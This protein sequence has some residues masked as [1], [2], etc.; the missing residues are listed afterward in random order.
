MVRYK[1]PIIEYVTSL[2]RTGFDKGLLI[3]LRNLDGTVIGGIIGYFVFRW[4]EAG[5]I[6]QRQMA[7]AFSYMGMQGDQL[8][9]M[10]IFILMGTYLG[11]LIFHYLIRRLK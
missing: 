1:N 11:A 10:V 2:F 5:M 4:Y 8:L 3:L 6:L 7:R 9:R